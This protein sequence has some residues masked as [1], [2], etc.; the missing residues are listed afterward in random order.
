MPADSRTGT[1]E[2]PK[3]P[4]TAT[5][6]VKRL[7]LPAK[8]RNRELFLLI[9]AAAVVLVQ[10]GALGHV[11]LT[12]VYL[13]AGLSALVLGMHIALRFV[14]PQA[15][16]FLLPIAT[17]LTGIGIAEI[18]RID[19]HYKDAGWDSAGVK[20]IVWSAIAIIC[21]LAVIIVIRNH[22]VLQRYTYLFGFAALILL[23]L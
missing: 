17:V 18:Y 19:I 21:A 14:A 13:G 3:P 7:R 5:G 4:R 2:Q 16:P 15:D 9:I 10:L 11:D 20:Q 8:L 23:L 6:P 1:R 22:R 12:L